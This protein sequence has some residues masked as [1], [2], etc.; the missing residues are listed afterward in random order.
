MHFTRGIAFLKSVGLLM[1]VVAFVAAGAMADPSGKTFDESNYQKTRAFNELKLFNPGVKAYMS[2][3]QI[4]RLYGE[5]FAFGSSPEVTASEFVR[6][7]AGI[8]GV[9]S[10]ELIPGNTTRE[11]TTM[12][13]VMFDNITGEYKFN[14]YYYSH[15][16]EG[17][18]VFGSE[19]RLL[20]RNEANYPLVLASSSIHETGNFEPDRNLVG[21]QS[22]LAL[23]AVKAKY[24]SLT[25]FTEQ[26]TVI[27]A[28]IEDQRDEPRMAVKFLGTSDFPESY[29]FV[30]DSK[31]G[32]ILYEEDRIV[33]E[34][35]DV[36]VAGLIT[37]MPGSEQCQ[38]EVSKAMPFLRVNIGSTMAYTDQYGNATI[39][40][41]GTSDV[42]VQ[43]QLIGQ[44]FNV[45]NYTGAEAVLVDTVT[46]PGPAEFVFNSANNSEFVR[47][48]ANAY[49]E[50]NVIRSTV[51]HFNPSYPGMSVNQF[52]VYVNRTD[53]YCPGNAWYDPDDQSVNFCTADDGYPNTAWSSVIH[54]EYGHYLVNQ[55]G[56]GQGQYGE[57]LGDC[58]SV[59]ISDDARLGL[60]FYGSCSQSL[61]TADNTF[62]YPCGSDI[63]TCAQLLSGCV[64][65]TR[66]ALV[67]NNVRD[68]LDVLKNLTVNSILLHTGTEIT[69]QITIDWLTIDDNDG[70]ISNGTPHYNEI[71]A[72][73]GLHNMDAPELDLL[74]FTYPNGLPDILPPN[75][76]ETIQVVVTGVAGVPVS[77]TGMLYYSVNGGGYTSISMI[78]TGT[79]QY[80][81]IIPAQECNSTVNYYF[82]AETDD[83]LVVYDPTYGSS[84]KTVVA[85]DVIVGFYD[86]FE[87]NLGWTISGGL[88]ARGTPT[89]GGGQYG[90]PDPSSAYEGSNVMGYNLS[91]DYSNGM[92]ERHVTTPAIDCSGMVGTTLKFQRWL[93]V[94]GS[95]YDHAYVRI[96][97]NGS[98]WTTLW[99]NGASMYDGAW[100]PIEI[101]ISSYADGQSTVY[102]RWTMGTTDGGWTYCGWNID[103]VEVSAYTCSSTP[104]LQITTETL[105]NWTLGV[106]YSQQLTAANGV[107]TLTW[108]DLNGNLAGTGLTLS[109]SGLLSGTPAS[110]GVISFT[111]QVVDESKA[112]A[113]KPLSFTINA[114][115]QIT[116]SAL[117]DWT[118]GYPLSVQLQSSGGT[119]TITWND[120][121]DDLDGTGL[122][123]SASGLL[124]GT[125][126]SEG[127]I[128]FT[129]EATDPLGSVDE[130]ALGFMV[131]PAIVITT[132]GFPNWTAGLAFSAQLTAT[133]GTG[134]VTWS[135]KNS[136]LSGTGLTLSPTG[137]LSGTPITTGAINFTAKAS[138]QIGAYSEKALS[139]Y[140]NPAVNITTVDLPDW[141]IN[142]A[143]SQTIVATGGTGGLTF[144][145]KNGD[146]APTG[147][148][149]NSDGTITGTP[150][151]AGP[152]SFV[153]KAADAIGAFSERTIN[154]V[155]NAAPEITTADLPNW[156]AGV[157]YSQAIVATGGT[158][159]LA[160]SD[161]NG[162]LASTGL[163]LNANGTVSGTPSGAATVNFTAE[164]ADEVGATTEKAFS[165]EINPAVAITTETLPGGDQEVAYSQALAATGGT[166]TIVWSDLDDD[167]DGT[168][169][170]L[171]AEG[172]VSG[173]PVIYGTIE[174][175]ARAVD[176]VGGTATRVFTIEINPAFIC[177]D[178]DDDGNVNLVDILWIIDFVYNDGE[179]PVYYN[180][181][182][183][184][185]SGN[186][187]LLDIL[188][189]IGVVYNETGELNCP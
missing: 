8:F 13:P 7:H 126:V 84:Y 10:N 65:D 70:N 51:V 53:G 140:I 156:T 152:I 159:D 134:T 33:F 151:S 89:G 128:N 16:V 166:G 150:V 62:Q 55:A 172:L 187:D 184:D 67:A 101:D 137:L 161:K 52:P 171:S 112:T 175:T 179:P 176:Q 14:L 96:S 47:S 133:G 45:I 158:G 154:F 186:V 17:I 182:D 76:P 123:L 108:S 77:G 104:E 18:P 183:V 91:G 50:T 71:A 106:A 48:Q 185:S 31:T 83:D 170:T 12:Q 66:E 82:S 46:P 144:T 188:A 39:P 60:G 153:A 155:I 139:V 68:Y 111:A 56:S 141:T 6:N 94:E 122:T 90:G 54:H 20:V 132:S 38:E 143:Y 118:A 26:E 22:A 73:F 30:V 146:L 29:L 130:A 69:P 86:G 121:N 15:E 24:P 178:A 58:M 103:N 37:Q 127:T 142:I 75:Q 125:P 114:A 32:E 85:T 163:T 92:P 23:D 131:S 28:G 160:F 95:D 42:I 173:T 3:P 119:G 19:L 63:H 5:A 11:K 80:N 35:V 1:L 4:T 124:S 97:T 157:A 43:A 138:D 57:G 174:F 25:D 117:A 169:L 189:I 120:K 41:T 93:G 98:T 21:V 27:W 78:V 164:V 116:T 148:V 61:R 165:F 145:D 72:G 102:L 149:L 88:W 136:N 181:A 74:D 59:V 40:N 64:W 113:Q 107:G 109:T 9:N 167:L 49:Y 87:T 168:G 180:A 36:E 177:G 34:D 110:A 2:G 99:Q 135:D 44:W 115:V 129:A 79:N 105:P 81:A 147:L 100:I 162:D